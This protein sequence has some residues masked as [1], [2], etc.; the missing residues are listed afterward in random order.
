MTSEVEIVVPSHPRWLRMVRT[1]VQEF[2]AE[3]GC[4][5]KERHDIALAVGEAVSN[6]I[7][8]SYKGNPDNKLTLV[9]RD[10]DDSF[11]VEIRDRG[12]AYDPHAKPMRPPEE[13]RVGGRGVYLMRAL[14]DEV[15]YHRAG[16]VNCVR[17][18]KLLKTHA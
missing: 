7:K 6:V 16:D 8:H 12:E 4:D 5:P 2:V 14:M 9:C 1:V 11:E 10:H 3:M 13:I 17:M 18:K 15:E